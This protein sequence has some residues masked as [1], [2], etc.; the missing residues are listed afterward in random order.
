MIIAG[1]AILTNLAPHPQPNL[2]KPAVKLSSGR[3]QFTVTLWL[4]LTCGCWE[5]TWYLDLM[6]LALAAS[7]VLVVGCTATLNIAFLRSMLTAPFKLKLWLRV[8]KYQPSIFAN[9]QENR[10]PFACITRS[11]YLVYLNREQW[12]RHVVNPRLCSLQ[13]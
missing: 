10:T 9:R 1:Q 2:A 7:L 13:L 3:K 12:P 6:W 5:T 8:V 11:I 4:C